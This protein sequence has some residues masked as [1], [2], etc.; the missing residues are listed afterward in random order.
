M[1]LAIFVCLV[2]AVAAA[3]QDYYQQ[4]PEIRLLS[5][6]FNSDDKGNYEYGY[7]QDNG[8]RVEEVGKSIPGYEPET[9]SISKVGSFE[10]VSPEGQQFRV[11]YT[12]GEEGFLPSG[13]HLPVAPAQLP[14]YQA[15]QQQF[16]ELY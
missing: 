6:R 1:K 4:Q 5:Y 9:G 10:F 14:E 16:P 7:E 3:P 15:H 13:A 8:Q 12:S 2:A 11:D